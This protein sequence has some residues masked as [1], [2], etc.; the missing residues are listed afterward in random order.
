LNYV[1]KNASAA[2]EILFDLFKAWKVNIT[3]TIAT[4]LLTAIY[5]DSLGFASKKTSAETLAKAAHLIKRGADREKVVEKTFQSWSPQAFKVWTTLLSNMKIRKSI[6][7]SQISYK[8]LRKTGCSVEDL[9]PARGFAA[10]KLLLPITEVKAAAIFTEEKP[11]KVRVSMRSKG[12]F[13]IE[14]IAKMMG[15]GGH[16]TSSAFDY[17]G[18]L[19][20]AVSKTLKHLTK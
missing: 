10:S 7:Y 11:N 6:A 16:A 13:S 8:E 14:K 19:K 20:D 4:C 17:N 2:A 12:R 5:T 9:S 3:E 15:G 1:N 18:K